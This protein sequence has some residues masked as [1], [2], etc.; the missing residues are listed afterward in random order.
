LPL[1]SLKAGNDSIQNNYPV[2]AKDSISN[3]LA[4]AVMDSSHTDAPIAA[5]D[6]SYHTIWARNGVRFYRSDMQGLCDSM[7]YSTRD[8]I[9]KMYSNP[10]V[11][12]EQ[13]QVSGEYME[14]K[15]RNNNP[16]VL[17]IQKSAI[18]ITYEQDSLYN[19]Y[20]GKDL[21]AYFGDSNQVVRVE[22]TGNAE[23]V[24]L[25]RDDDSELSG[26]N[27]LEGSSIT[28]FRKDGKMEKLIVWPQ[29]K[30][31]FYPMDK[32]EPD[33]RFLKNF[34]W[35]EKL[36]PK[37]PDDVFR[38]VEREK[39]Q[40]ANSDKRI[41]KKSKSLDK[42]SVEKPIEKVIE[43]NAAEAI[44]E[45]KNTEAIPEKEPI[46]MISVKDTIDTVKQ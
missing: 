17:N 27:R 42:D 29:P 13:Q 41:K 26:L 10:V 21:K 22:I 39:S 8:S 11:W 35:L 31:K 6:S 32:I 20:S 43:K 2:A 25:P 16:D 3:D 12:S 23:T 18:A 30:G 38:V 4:V 37:N 14:L 34:V 1:D 33:A 7:F 19:Q 45:K 24:Y 15:T 9:L 44:P 40:K 36:R 28:M 46:N 5:G